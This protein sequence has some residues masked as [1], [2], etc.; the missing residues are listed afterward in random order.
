MIIKKKSRENSFSDIVKLNGNQRVQQ[1][2]ASQPSKTN[3]SRNRR[4][5]DDDWER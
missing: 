5:D 2:Y 4:R 3:S 1:Q